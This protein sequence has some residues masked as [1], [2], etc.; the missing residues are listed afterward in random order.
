MPKRSATTKNV[1]LL[2]QF[3][4]DNQL[5]LTTEFQRNAVW[6]TKAK[7][8]LIDT[9]LN[10]QPIPIFFLQ[11]TTSA[12]T[13]RPA[14]V[15]VDGQQRLRAIFEFL[16]DRFRLTQSSSKAPY[17]RRKFSEL[18]FSLQE[19]IRNY[20]LTVDE[21]SAYSDADIVDMFVRMNKYVVKLSQQ[22]LR[23]ARQHGK[24]RD[25]VEG[26]GR[27]DFW[28]QY[29]V[30]SPLQIRRM[31]AVEFAAELTI[32]FIEG[33]QDKKKALD[34]Y[35]GKYEKAF[36][37]ANE[38]RAGLEAYL[39][40]IILALPQLASTRFRK[41]VDLYSLIGA[42]DLVT[43]GGKRLSKLDTSK[44]GAAL[45]KFEER[46]RSGSAGGDAAKYVV[47]AS[48]QTD[49]IMP[50]TTRIGILSKLLTAGE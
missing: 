24:F 5:T 48:R 46:T 47:A 15:V 26:L 21:L 19:Q 20:D 3:N 45:L 1:G 25:F 30:F 23:H 38:V 31:R 11:R 34:L 17:Y 29:R 36:P 22:E 7:A 37:Y 12:Q 44:A 13:G 39:K 42:L 18:P 14:Y 2:W 16:E 40:W 43:E 32:L 27:L 50:R 41:P 9:I 33:P 8:Y 6:P 4:Q 10:D 35:Y 28:T 49:N